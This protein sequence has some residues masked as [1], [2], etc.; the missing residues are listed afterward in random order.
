MYL[1]ILFPDQSRSYMQKLIEAGCVRVNGE[2]LD[3]S[4]RVRGGDTVALEFRTEKYHLEAEDMGLEV[5]FDNPDFAVINKDP[6]VNTHTVPGEHGNKGTLVNALLHHFEGLSVINGVERPGIVHRLDKDTS[7]LIMI[8][9]NDRTMV[10][11]QKKMAD[12][13][14]RKFYLAVVVGLVKDPEGI[15]E[16]YIGRDAVD[17]KIMTTVNPVNPKLSKTKFR[18]IEH[19]S[20]KYSFVEIELFTGRTHQI[21]VHMAAIGHPIVGDKTY[22]NDKVN[23]EVLERTGLTRQ[24]LHA[25]RLILNL[26]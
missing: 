18:L 14:V 15:I 6:G 22:G 24:W 20:G 17:R 21:R 7:G 9:K 2:L 3:R 16:S 8:A 10:T 13:K 4:K 5:V 12:R 1:S 23:K 26:F 25:R 11:I 19:L